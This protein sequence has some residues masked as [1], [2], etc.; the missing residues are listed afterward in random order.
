MKKILVSLFIFIISLNVYAS[1]GSIKQSSVIKCDGIYYGS[2]SDHWHIVKLENNKYVIKDNKELSAPSCYKELKNE[3]EKVK[4]SKCVDGDTAKFIMEDGSVKTAR[5]LAIDTPESVHPKKEV[6][7]YGKEASEFTCNLL[8]NAKSLKVEYDKASEKTD[9]YGRILV[10]V[11]AD[12]KLVQE[13]LLEE[14]Y[15]K[16]AYLYAS[17]EYTD[18]LKSVESIAKSKKLRIWS[19]ENV[20]NNLSSTDINDTDTDTTNDSILDII[21]KFIEDFL[22][23][24]FKKIVNLIN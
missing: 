18:H 5:F 20:S 22:T 6:E 4:L 10:W 8:T 15:A 24:L 13:T 23:N 3:T 19:D 1:S 11:Y 16:V 21:I 17:Y 7:A 12:D 14:G 2:H 9:K